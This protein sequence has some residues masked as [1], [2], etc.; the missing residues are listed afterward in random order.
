MLST[1]KK[2][3]GASYFAPNTLRQDEP[4]NIGWLLLSSLNNS[5]VIKVMSNECQ[6]IFFY[7]KH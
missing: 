3:V 4:P 1:S 7:V 2:F 6:N 5:N